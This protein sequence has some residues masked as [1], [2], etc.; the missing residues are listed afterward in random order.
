MAQ[1]EC[2]W[3]CFSKVSLTKRDAKKPSRVERPAQSPPSSYD[4]GSIAVLMQAIMEPP[5]NPSEALAMMFTVAGNSHTFG[6]F[7][8]PLWQWPGKMSAVKKATAPVPMKSADHMDKI[9]HTGSPLR[10]MSAD[11]DIASGKFARKTATMNAMLSV[12]SLCMNPISIDSGTP[13]IRMPSQMEKATLLLSFCPSALFGGGGGGSGIVASSME[14]RL[15]HRL[16]RRAAVEG[17]KAHTPRDC[18][19]WGI[20]PLR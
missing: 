2:S 7:S 10:N 11:D 17:P 9:F 1:T 12:P 8:S 16:V 6:A 18:N 13:S 14:R 15:I 19:R 3:P 20:S 5:A 4:S